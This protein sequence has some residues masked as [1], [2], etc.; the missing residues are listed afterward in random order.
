MFQSKTHIKLPQEC[1]ICLELVNSKKDMGNMTCSHHFHKQC[2]M[3]WLVSSQNKTQN[4]CPV[5][6]TGK[7]LHQ[8]KLSKKRN[9]CCI[10][11]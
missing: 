9:L 4:D 5:C 6:Y 1:Y 11:L 8:S 3:D 7:I 2:I 10:I